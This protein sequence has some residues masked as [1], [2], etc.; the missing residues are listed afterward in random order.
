MIEIKNT[1]NIQILSPKILRANKNFMFR[2]NCLT[3]NN[4]LEV[5]CI[6]LSPSDFKKF[7]SLHSIENKWM[8]GVDFLFGHFNI[9]TAVYNKF[10]VLHVL[11]SKSNQKEALEC[12]DN[13][14]K[15]NGF[16]SFEEITNKYEPIY[17]KINI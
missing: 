15:K 4:F 8:W 5:F 13:Y 16:S 9:I 2:S 3:F 10:E 1:Y 11:R 7:S 14:L 6:L 12:L 17:K